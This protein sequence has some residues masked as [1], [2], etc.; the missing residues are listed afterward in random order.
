MR[1]R[2][3]IVAGSVVALAVAGAATG[4]GVASGG[5]DRPIQGTDRDRATAAALASVGGGSVVETEI[6]DGGAAY[7]V[8]VRR[9]DG[10]VVEVQLD[11]RFRV[12]G[13]EADD[14][15]GTGEDGNGEPD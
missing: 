3:K 13:T 1:V 10:S 15:T 9:T 6:G 11:A 14:D 12:I 4:V 7:S 8:E 2:T 5:D